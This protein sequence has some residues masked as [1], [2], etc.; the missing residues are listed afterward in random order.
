MRA[1]SFPFF[2]TW[3]RK[4][5][6]PRSISFKTLLG[7]WKNF[8]F[9]HIPKRSVVLM[10]L[11]ANF[12]PIWTSSRRS[13]TRIRSVPSRSSH[14]PLDMLP[15]QRKC[16]KM[17]FSSTSML[18]LLFTTT[19]FSQKVANRLL[20]SRFTAQQIKPCLISHNK[21]GSIKTIRFHVLIGSLLAHLQ[22]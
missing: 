19:T 4:E 8:I 17:S 9:L 16:T 21:Y 13:T 6:L 3:R 10:I 2:A 20:L 1:D 14:G 15:S 18:S 7:W 11:L 22:R 5:I 12:I